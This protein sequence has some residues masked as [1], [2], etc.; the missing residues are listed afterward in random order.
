MADISNNGSGDLS[1]NSV[2]DLL[3]GIRG[4]GDVDIATQ[5]G[6]F[7]VDGNGSGDVRV[8]RGRAMPFL[9]S[10]SGS[11]DV[12]HGGEAVDADVRIN[13]SGSVSADSYS[14]NFRWQSRNGRV[15]HDAPA[16][17]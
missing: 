10:V 17:G 7:E 8:S 2:G 5:T 16:G 12:R 6:R 15:R 1:L 11:G 9:V 3:A 4:S 13:G 14:G